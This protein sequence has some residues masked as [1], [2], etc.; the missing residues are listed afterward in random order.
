L[1]CDELLWLITVSRHFYSPPFFAERV[2]GYGIEYNAPRPPFILSQLLWKSAL[3]V[4][5][6]W[7]W[8]MTGVFV[9]FLSGIFGFSAGWFDWNDDWMVQDKWRWR[10]REVGPPVRDEGLGWGADTALGS[11]EYLR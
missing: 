6:Q 5:F 4:P 7:L 1:H 2:D 11:D 10:F 9:R 3:G 8:F